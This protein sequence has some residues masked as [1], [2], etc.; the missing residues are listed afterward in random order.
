MLAK[1]ESLESSL[2]EHSATDIEQKI[3]KYEAMLKRE[4]DCENDK[5]KIS[6]D[7]KSIEIEDKILYDKRKKLSDELVDMMSRVTSDKSGD[8]VSNLR[9]LINELNDSINTADANRISLATT[10]G[11]NKAFI[12]KTKEEMQQYAKL[13]TKWNIYQ[14]FMKAV[15]KKGIPAQII[16]SQLPII[17]AE[18]AKILN[19]VVDFT[20]EFDAQDNNR[21]DIF[22]NY[23][24]TKR[25]IELGSG[26]EKMISSLAIRV[27]L[28]NISSLPKP[29]ILIVDEGFGALDENRVTACN[30]LL[31]SLKKWFKN[32]LVVSQSRSCSDQLFCD[33]M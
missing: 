25:I 27:A 26:M 28:L 1:I 9:G 20:V 7:I 17:N 31:T 19:G 22:I 4:Q 12:T 13:R 14:G 11:E 18:I 8:E 24:D 16:S 30:L 21:A 23:G 15:S 33:D 6:L 10:M 3:K 32:I 2:S 5:S 29:D